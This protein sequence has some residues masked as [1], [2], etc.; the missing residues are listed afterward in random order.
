[1]DKLKASDLIE[2]DEK[3]VAQIA[4]KLKGMQSDKNLDDIN[5][6]TSD[7]AK[8]LKVGRYTVVRYIENYVKDKYPNT[9]KL[10]AVKAGRS[11][12]IKKSDLELFLQN[13]KNPDYEHRS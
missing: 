13:P 9:P 11:W 7:V 2:I 4:E 10:K 8:L 12:L 3:F 5:L 1:M 6:T